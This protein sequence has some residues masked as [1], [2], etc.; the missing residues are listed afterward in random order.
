MWE[1][2]VAAE[3]RL[4]HRGQNPASKT[5]RSNAL[6]HYF[7]WLLYYAIRLRPA[8]PTPANRW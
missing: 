5:E 7:E 2:G 1:V 8:V 4:I 3:H 6:I